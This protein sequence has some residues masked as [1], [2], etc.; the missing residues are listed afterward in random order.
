[1]E[2]FVHAAEL[3][4]FSAAG[5]NLRLSPSAVSKLVTRIEERLGTR[6]FVRTTRAL[7]LTPEGE[8]YLEQARLILIQIQ[9]AERRV[10][11]GSASV[12]RGR[13]RV[14]ASVAFGS[15]YVVPLV[16]DFLAAYPDVELDLSLSDGVVDIVGERAD[17]AIRS[18]NLQDSSLKARK[19]LESRRVIVASPSYLLRAGTPLAPEDLDRHNCLTFNFRPILE[20]WPFL[21][22]SG[23]SVF[24]KVVRGN[25]E[26]NN[27]PSMRRLCLDGLGLCRIGEFHVQA[28]IETGKLVAL[29]EDFNPGEIEF[30]HAVYPGHE[31]LAARIRAF[32]EFLADRIK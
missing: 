1:M 7:E 18:G 12:P 5:R 11:S 15:Q 2:V 10:S 21:D 28:D 23:G 17:V 4:S 22:P 19:L 25:F 3:K 20:E 16:A 13:L 26:V 6:L 8:V 30:I 24:H 9:A 27:G 31:H 14:T 29:L 32:I